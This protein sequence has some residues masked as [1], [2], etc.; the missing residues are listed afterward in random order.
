MEKKNASD[1]IFLVHK[2]KGWSSFDIIRKLRKK[3]KI[4][5]I[6]HAGTLD[7][8]A[9]GLLIIGVGKATKQL[10]QFSELP[11]TYIMEVLLGKKT[12]TA[13]LEGAVIEEKIV[14]NI[15]IK[16][17]QTTL[18][19]LEGTLF[20]PAPLYSAI[21]IKGKPLY[22]YARQGIKIKPPLRK[23]RIFSLKLL[24]AQPIDKYYVLKIKME[25]AK[26]TYARSVA[27][28]IGRQ[29][30]LPATLKSLKRTAI[31]NYKSKNAKKIEDF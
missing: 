13:D 14:Q 3:L 22:Q 1:A 5:K 7:P 27:E 20:L 6:G 17:L 21:K 12:T 30:N 29:L 26:G 28:E 9:T 8:L 25:C 31:G 11:K 10:K 4:K 18:K 23:T 16:K 19:E 24:K 15:D 2:P